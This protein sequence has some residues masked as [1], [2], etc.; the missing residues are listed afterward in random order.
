MLG[1]LHPAAGGEE[2]EREKRC[3]EDGLQE[4]APGSLD[5]GK[6]GSAHLGEAQGVQ[7][8]PFLAVGVTTAFH[9]SQGGR[10][11]Q[12]R[13]PPLAMPRTRTH[14]IPQP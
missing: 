5:R 11:S 6:E 10:D 1:V 7:T 2:G 8:P 13:H 9:T 12:H 4:G 14:S 3:R